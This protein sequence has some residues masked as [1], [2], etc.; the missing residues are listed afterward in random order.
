MVG[1][2]GVVVVL[3]SIHP[4]DDPLA[5]SVVALLIGGAV[6]L[7]ACPM[8]WALRRDPGTRDGAWA[9]AGRRASLIGLVIGVLVLLRTIDALA[10]PVLIFL[11]GTAVVVELAFVVRGRAAG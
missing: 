3:T 5:R 1:W 6:A 2:F 7:T 4:E 8:L 11:L 10:L 9:A